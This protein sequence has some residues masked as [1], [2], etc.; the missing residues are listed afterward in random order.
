MIPR[1]ARGPIRWWLN[2]WGFDG[3]TLPPWGIF[4][5]REKLDDDRLYRHELTHWLQAQEVG[6]LWFYAYYIWFTLRFGYRNNPME[7]EA[8]AAETC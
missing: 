1:E 8:R 5:R 4:I 3:I 6:A 2:L 7:V